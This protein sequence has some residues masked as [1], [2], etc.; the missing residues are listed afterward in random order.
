MKASGIVTLTT[1]FGIRDHYAG[2]VRG[3]VLSINPGATLVDI[4]HCIRP[5]SVFDGAFVMAGACPVFPE[6]TVHVGVVDPGVGGE[7]RAVLIETERYLFVG[8]DN[9]LLSMAAERDGIRRVRELRKGDY[10]RRP[11]SRTFHGRDVFGPVAA[12]LTLGLDPS[13]LGPA[14]R[15]LEMIRVPEPEAGPGEIRGEVLHVD[16]YGNLLTNIGEGLLREHLGSGALAVLV[17]G[18]LVRGP[19]GSYA[20]ME[21][22]EPGALVGSLGVL[23]VA[24]REASAAETLG[25]GPGEKVMVRKKG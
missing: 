2:A 10:M 25:V 6:G 13:E 1:D 23:E 18:R 24:C 22:G 20:S 9:G 4:T 11:V 19:F 17:G 8:P 14:T 7:R 16:A 3:A 21:E 12:H 15:D 5:G